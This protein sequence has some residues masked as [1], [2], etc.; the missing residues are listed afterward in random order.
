MASQRRAPTKRPPRPAAKK[1]PPPGGT[2][3]LD[4]VEAAPGKGKAPA[5]PTAR[6]PKAAAKT[7]TPKSPTS[8]STTAAAPKTGLPA[9]DKGTDKGTDIGTDKVPTNAAK[10]TASAP[11]AKAKPSGPSGPNYRPPTGATRSSARRPPPPPKRK[12]KWLTKKSIG[13]VVALALVGT[14]VIFFSLA[15][16]GSSTDTNVSTALSGPE[17]VEVPKGPVL[18]AVASAHYPQTIDGIKCEVNE[19]LVYHIHSHLT[20]FVNG[21]ARQIPYG[22]G[23]TPPLQYNTSN[24]TYVNGG[25]CFYWLHTH[26]ADGIIHIESPTQ[27]QYTLGQFFD[28]WGQTLKAGQVGPAL[29]PLKMYVDG[30]PY[31]GDPRAIALGAHS[32]IQLDIGSPAPGPVT[33]TYPSSM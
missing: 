1:P 21:Q 26:A 13:A 17:Q 29:G 12:K 11:A 4:A 6:S 23:M 8:R 33:I 10:S 28:M 22:I 27:T 24:G 32:Q 18:A 30:K 31:T 7:S 3:G 14:L 15:V 5:S 19:Q 2:E 9:T 25:Q 20:I 16:N